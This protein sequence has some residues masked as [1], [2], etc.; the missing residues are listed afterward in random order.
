MLRYENKYSSYLRVYPYIAM[1][2]NSL[3]PDSDVLLK[4]GPDWQKPL[5]L[6]DTNN[7]SQVAVPA[8]LRWSRW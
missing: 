6:I 8:G 3:E 2:A 7:A 5:I 4:R 1:D